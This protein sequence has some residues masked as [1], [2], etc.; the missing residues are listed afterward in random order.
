MVLSRG[1][2]AQAISDISGL[3][4]PYREMVTQWNGLFVHNSEVDPKHPQL[5]PKPTQADGQGLPKARPARTEPPVLILLQPNSF[6]TVIYNGN[7]YINVYS[8]NHERTTGNIVRF[9][10]PTSPVGF[11]TIPT[12]DGVSDI[13]N[14]NGFTIT[15]GKINSSGSVSKPINYFYFQSDDNAIT[16]NVNGGGA[17]CSAGPVN[18]VG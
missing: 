14:A 12:F 18:L 15:V 17:A 4:F 11:Q 5:E 10:G 16:G 9:Y 13:S 2:Y 1:K 8:Q 6:E 7:T 3:A